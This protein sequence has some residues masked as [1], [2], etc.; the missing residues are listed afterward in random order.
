[1]S[2]YI[3]QYIDIILLNLVTTGCHKMNSTNVVYSKQKQIVV[4]KPR[5]VQLQI[6]LGPL[7]SA[8]N[9]FLL[10]SWPQIVEEAVST[11]LYIRKELNK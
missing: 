11:Y 6:K 10:R 1:M 8:L 7:L 9:L 5:E 4:C 3:A 2:N